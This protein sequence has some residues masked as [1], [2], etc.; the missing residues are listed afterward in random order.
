MSRPAIY[1][2]GAGG[3]GMSALVRYFLAKDYLVAGY[4]KTPTALTD[5]LIKEGAAIHFEDNV[6][7]IPEYCKDKAN[8]LVVR[9][10]AVPLSHAELSWFHS[11]DFKILK[12][13]QLLGEITKMS[14]GLCVAG[15][16]GKTT[17]STMLAH[18]LKES[19]VDCNAFLGGIV[20]N[21]SSNLLLSDHSD[22]TV[23][24]ADEYDRSFHALH[25]YMAIITSTDPDHLDIYGTKEAYLES[26]EH[27]SSLIC[28]DGVLI[29]KQGLEFTPKTK[30][31]VKIYT[32]STEGDADFHA[33][34]IRIGN[35]TIIFDFISP[36]GNVKDAE[37]GVPVWIN[38]E[39]SIAAMAVAQLNGVTPDELRHGVKSYLGAKRRFDFWVKQDNKVL[40]DDYGHHPE[41]VKASIRSV[42]KLFEGRKV[43]VIFQPHL[44]S[45]TRDFYPEF[46]EALSQADEVI[47]LD[48]YP[49]REEPIEGVTSD[50]IFDLIHSAKKERVSKENLLSLLSDKE[51]DVLVTLGAGDIDTMLPQIQTIIER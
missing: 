29:V 28:S 40:L 48:I 18:I 50:L 20:K 12:R 34:N 2:I 38:I 26:F 35:G 27:F 13:A 37:L 14:R 36:F 10:P 3:I 23:I 11:Q 8:T 1:F 5:A 4:D 41:E 25:P 16:H 24:E 15:T 31:G 6:D 47:L 7:L 21:Y 43:T 32:Y 17:T 39:N 44:Y 49:A 51:T 22:L 9:T 45:R 42:K 19:H 46:A 33:E 30:E